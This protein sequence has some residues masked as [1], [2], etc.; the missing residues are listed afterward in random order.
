[1]PTRGTHRPADAPA[2]A[3]P[4]RARPRAQSPSARAGAASR[5]RPRR[6]PARIGSGQA[7]RAR[8]I[9]GDR[10]RLGEEEDAVCDVAAAG[11]RAVRGG[12]V[13]PAV[14]AR[15]AVAAE[16]AGPVALVG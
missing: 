15:A 3:S 9:G 2:A 10:V 13:E 1:A 11:D 8:T 14:D 4:A 12:A 7:H 16:R 5:S 6:P